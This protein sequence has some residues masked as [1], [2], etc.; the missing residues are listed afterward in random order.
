ME[1]S[2]VFPESFDVVRCALPLFD[3]HRSTVSPNRFK[4]AVVVVAR[5][6]A[7]AGFGE[8]SP[9]VKPLY[10]EQFLDA[11]QS[12]LL[13]L[14]AELSRKFK[15][16]SSF[17]FELYRSTI[18]SVRGWSS[19]KFAIDTALADLNGRLSRLGPFGSILNWFSESDPSV[20]L[21]E[22]IVNLDRKVGVSDFNV[23]PH[24]TSIGDFTVVVPDFIDVS[25]YRRVKIKVDAKVCEDPSWLSQLSTFVRDVPNSI[26]VVVDFNESAP[27][28]AVLAA[29][30]D[31]PI[32]FLE[33]P[34]G[35]K[36]VEEG[37]RIFRDRQYKVAFDESLVDEARLVD[38]D[39]AGLFDIAVVKPHRFDSVSR[40][41]NALERLSAGRSGTNTLGR[42]YI[43]GMYDLPVLRRLI[44][45]LTTIFP[46][47][48]AS[49]LGPDVDYFSA[50]LLP[51]V[52][53]GVGTLKV[54]GGVGLSGAF[55]PNR[56][57]VSTRCRIEDGQITKVD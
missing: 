23:A 29:L 54:I 34:Y 10:E 41:V 38:F 15:P 14:L 2:G 49:D 6:G 21:R 52:V 13:D 7:D 57:Y 53:A 25:R 45:V 50:P 30:S 11:A 55:V 43:G 9:L 18:D 33:A 12:V 47:G 35:V 16:G 19:A 56:K 20:V 26:D 31:E 39:N 36:T 22:R 46:D 37:L 8:L 42:F 24:G 44:A 5:Y 4:E 17:D 1:F 28:T 51:S 40:L 3:H 27:S 32:K 48:E